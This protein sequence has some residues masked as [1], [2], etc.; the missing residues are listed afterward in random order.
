MGCH[1][2]LQ[3]IFLT[4]LLLKKEVWTQ[5]SFIGRCILHRRAT[6]EAW[7]TSETL[8]IKTRGSNMS[9]SNS[10]YFLEFYQLKTQRILSQFLFTSWRFC[11]AW[12]WL[13]NFHHLDQKTAC[14]NAWCRARRVSIVLSARN[15]EEKTDSQETLHEEV[16]LW[17]PGLMYQNYLESLYIYIYTKKNLSHLPR[18][19]FSTANVYL[20][21]LP[22]FVHE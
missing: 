21:I 22:L 9:F 2:L 7:M 6:R 11:F 20:D 5:A 8:K 19:S 13:D 18:I 10:S 17:F 1:F 14:W 15:V 16:F 3:G 12:Y 4:H